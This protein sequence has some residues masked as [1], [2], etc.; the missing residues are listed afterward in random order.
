M[1]LSPAIPILICPGMHP[2]N[3]T[4]AFIQGLGPALQDCGPVH[5]F[6]AEHE[7]AISGLHI[8]HFIR[9]RLPLPAGPWSQSQPALI[10]ISFSAGVVG[11]AQMAWLWQGL[12]GRLHRFFALDGWGVPLPPSWPLYRLSHDRCTD[13][14]SAILGV[15]CDRFFA[16]PPVS[17]AH[18]WQQPHQTTGWWLHQA[19]H[20]PAFKIPITA[21]DFMVR[22]A[23]E[24]PQATTLRS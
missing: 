11:A 20:G 22:C 9:E 19:I 2:P 24:S 16:D 15:G 17:H 5:V 14:S 13:W 3:W 4:A 7:P 6:P 18:L 12:G 10:V 23:G 8:L 1:S 21:A